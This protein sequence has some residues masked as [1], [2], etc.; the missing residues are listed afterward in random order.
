MQNKPNRYRKNFGTT[1]DPETFRV[2]NALSAVSRKGHF[3]D[4]V[5]SEWLTNCALFEMPKVGPVMLKHQGLYY[6]WLDM[7]DDEQSPQFRKM[8]DGLLWLRSEYP[9]HNK[10]IS[11]ELGELIQA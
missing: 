11:E 3:L 4:K 5:I 7:N 1:L 9:S 2:I 8:I 6:C 10:D